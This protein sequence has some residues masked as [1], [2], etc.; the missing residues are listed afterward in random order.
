MPLTTDS[1]IDLATTL[2][3]EKAMGKTPKT[4]AEIS[5]ISVHVEEWVFGM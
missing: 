1:T 4:Q 5:A 3:I 2:Q